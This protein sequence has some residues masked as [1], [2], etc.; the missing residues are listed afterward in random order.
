MKEISALETRAIYPK[1]N[2]FVRIRLSLAVYDHKQFYRSWQIV[3]AFMDEYGRRSLQFRFTFHIVL[4]YKTTTGITRGVHAKVAW[5]PMKYHLE[6][7]GI[8]CASN[9]TWATGGSG[10]PVRMERDGDPSSV[11]FRRILFWDRF[12]GSSS[13]T[14]C[15]VVPCRF[16]S[17]D[18]GMMRYAGFT[19]VLAGGRW[20]HDT[21]R[22]GEFV[23]ARVGR[24]IPRLGPRVNLA[25][26]EAIWFYDWLRRGA[27]LPGLCLD[28][29]GDDVGMEL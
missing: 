19:L 2:R 10:T 21:L 27:P 9:A 11:G 16:V 17:P 7:S 25:K 6:W 15:F 20:W 8:Y 3:N 24:A 4:K 5:Y 28:M 23:F 29:K 18:T 26:L 1:V 22:H 13:T 14:R 12:C